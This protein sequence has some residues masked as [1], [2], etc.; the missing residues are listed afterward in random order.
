MKFLR[1]SREAELK[2]QME[3]GHWPQ[4]STSDLR[5]HVA[6]CK[7]CQDAALLRQSFRQ[8]RA[9]TSAEAQLPPPGLLWWRAQLRRR[10]AA[11]ARVQKPIVG[12]QIFALLVTLAL[13]CGFVIVEMRSDP[14]GKLS[15]IGWMSSLSK[16][17]TLHLEGLLS[18]AS[19][20]FTGNPLFLTPALVVLVLMGG[21]AAL[22][23]TDKS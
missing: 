7:A 18:T 6:A 1:C 2:E 12:A 10:N 5:A 13:A 15:L 19:S 21:L 16:S 3:S 11:L 14:D 20:I 9:V 23:V 4:A 8:A 17:S 22:L